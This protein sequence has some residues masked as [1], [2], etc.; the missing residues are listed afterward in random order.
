[1]LIKT[2]YPPRAR[3]EFRL[4]KTEYR[5]FVTL[6]NVEPVVTPLGR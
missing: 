5:A 3:L 2:S 6:R 4:D 1:M